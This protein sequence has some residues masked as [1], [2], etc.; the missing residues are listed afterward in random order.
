MPNLCL[1]F[2]SVLNLFGMDQS[3][4]VLVLPSAAAPF[5]TDAWTASTQVKN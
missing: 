3:S 4:V 5:V 1:P 2:E